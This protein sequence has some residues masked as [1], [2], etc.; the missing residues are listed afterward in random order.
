MNRARIATSWVL[1]VGVLVGLLAAL[2]PSPRIE[3][4]DPRWD[5]RTMGNHVC[6][7]VQVTP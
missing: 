3:E 2:T 5:C 4:D 6:G 1:V 7:P